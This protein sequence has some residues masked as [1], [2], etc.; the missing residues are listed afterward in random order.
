MPRNSLWGL[1]TLTFCE[2]DVSS[3]SA[4]D[5]RPPHGALNGGCLEA[6]GGSISDPHAVPR[7]IPL[8]P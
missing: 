4:R 6:P 1:A 7:L 3:V 8:P 5:P 2:S